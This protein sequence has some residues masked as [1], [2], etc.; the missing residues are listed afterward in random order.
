MLSVRKNIVIL[1]LVAMAVSMFVGCGAPA[2]T[3]E[4]V[5]EEERLEATEEPA[6]EEEPAEE[7]EAPTEVN[8]A[9]IYSSAVEQPW[10]TAF[11]QA[12]DRV[13]EEKP[14][15]LTVNLDFTED[16][17]PPDAERVLRQ[18]ADTGEYDILWAHSAYYDAVNVLKDEYPEYL[19]V[20]AGSGYEP[21]GGNAYRVDVVLHEP[22]YLTGVIAGAMTESD[23]IGAVAA[24][25]FPNV[26]L[27]LNAYVAG[28]RSVNEDVEAKVTYIE[29]WFDPPKGK[30][31]AVALISSGADMI[32]AERFGP[33]EA[34]KEEGAYC[35][36]H[37]VDQRSMAP[38]V[39]ITGP[40]ARWDPAIKYIIDT[41]RDHVTLGAPYDA[42]GERVIFNM[43]E[44]GSTLG[45]VG[46]MVPEDV[47][48]LVEDAEERIKSGELEVPFNEAPIE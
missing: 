46:D 7:E 38:D 9:A 45:A 30:E 6:A 24:F 8:I 12:I 14:H 39:V 37:F 5:A 32:Y 27:P 29:S 48:E 18:Y 21:M 43:A 44:G 11:M 23:V 17:A 13:Q 41:W 26:N 16:V 19:W 47:M 4:P 20:G 15:G 33:F 35:F 42:P 40:V 25:P 31:S 1:V 36:G 22:A 34:C 28:A 2:A 10:V 3:E